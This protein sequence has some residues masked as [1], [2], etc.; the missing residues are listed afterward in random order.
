MKESSPAING[1]ELEEPLHS[2][3]S[4]I[5]SFMRRAYDQSGNLIDEVAVLKN[6]SDQRTIV[7]LSKGQLTQKNEFTLKELETGGILP[8]EVV[9]NGYQVKIV[10][11]PYETV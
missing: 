6:G 4:D 8:H 7:K 5:G 10:L 2:M 11:E 1:E 9:D 3:R